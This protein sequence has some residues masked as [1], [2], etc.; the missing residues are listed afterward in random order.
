M[1][2]RFIYIVNIQK[3]FKI[4]VLQFDYHRRDLMVPFL[5][6]FLCFSFY[7]IPLDFL[8]YLLKQIMITLF[9]KK[10]I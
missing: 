8:I 5:S 2:L 3:I 9:L 7:K 4:K 6:L 10:V 1:Y